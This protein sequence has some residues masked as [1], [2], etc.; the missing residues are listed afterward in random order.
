MK[1]I[2]AIYSLVPMSPLED[3][4]LN[5]TLGEPSTEG[6]S[7]AEIRTSN[8]VYNAALL[9]HYSSG[10]V[11]QRFGQTQHND[12]Q[13]AA[14][15]PGGGAPGGVPGTDMENS[16][17]LN[18]GVSPENWESLD[19]ASSMAARGNLAAGTSA[20][21]H[22]GDGGCGDVGKSRAD[23]VLDCGLTEE[24]ESVAAL[25]AL[26]EE[27]GNEMQDYACMFPEYVPM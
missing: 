19:L 17:T 15:S 9:Q 12:V 7:Q 4:L 6:P 5:E 1:A 10:A 24:E 8:V 20:T 3:W 23:R 27:V 13:G 21:R 2:S 22:L 11:G 25:E 26:Y 14:R 18:S 16:S